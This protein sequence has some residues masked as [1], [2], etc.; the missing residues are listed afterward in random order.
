[1]RWVNNHVYYLKAKSPVGLRILQTVLALPYEDSELWR[2]HV[3]DHMCRPYGYK[4]VTDHV[5]FRDVYNICV[6]KRVLAAED[7]KQDDLDN[8]LF[9]YPLVRLQIASETM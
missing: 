9:D 2:T 5:K 8:V 3:L 1:M 6:L 4:P 7:N